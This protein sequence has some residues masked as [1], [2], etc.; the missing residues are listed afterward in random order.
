[1]FNTTASCAAAER[2]RAQWEVGFSSMETAKSRCFRMLVAGCWCKQP[3]CQ[4]VLEEK[5]VV[6]VIVESSPSRGCKGSVI[7]LSQ[8]ISK[9]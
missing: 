3:L 2:G 4:A 5:G 6:I 8:R 9:E 7:V 1:M